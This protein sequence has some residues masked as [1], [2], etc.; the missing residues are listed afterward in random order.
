MIQVSLCRDHGF[1]SV[2]SYEGLLLCSEPH[3]ERHDIKLSI[4]IVIQFH[5]NTLLP[6]TLERFYPIFLKVLLL[7]ARKGLHSCYDII[8]RVETGSAR[9]VFMSGNRL[10]LTE[11]DQ[12]SKVSAEG[13]QN[14]TCA[15]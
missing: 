12:E 1:P 5:I 10:S 4:I 9:A 14:H 3:V 2:T 15:L 13:V 7:A 11:P 6:T 8:V